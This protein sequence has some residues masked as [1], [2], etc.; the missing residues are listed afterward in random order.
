MV[1][2]RSGI[3]LKVQT[4]SSPAPRTVARAGRVMV[5]W[6]SSVPLG[7][8]GLASGLASAIPPLTATSSPD[9]PVERTTSV[10]PAGTVTG[11]L[12]ARAATARRDAD[13]AG[14]AAAGRCRSAALT[15]A[16]IRKLAGA[17]TPCQSNAAAMRLVRSPPAAKNVATTRIST[18]RAQR[19]RIARGKLRHRRAGLER[20]G[21]AQR[22]LQMRA[23]ERGRELVAGLR[24]HAIGDGGGRPVRQEAGAIEPPQAVDRGGPADLEQRR[25]SQPP[26][27]RR[28]RTDRSRGRA[29]ATKPKARARTAPGTVRSRSRST[30]APA[31]AA[32]RISPSGRGGARASSMACPARAVVIAF[33][34]VDF[35]SR[36]APGARNLFVTTP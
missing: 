24:R 34:I 18:R 35:G 14:S 28:R 17:T 23:P 2:A 22:A 31:R 7:A 13:P 27:A 26:P 20:L 16:S 21:G 6:R 30:P 5:K 12:P 19:I 1:G 11:P 36:A 32:P 15:Q 4:T 25:R 3:A 29:A 9:W 10:E 33:V 8:C